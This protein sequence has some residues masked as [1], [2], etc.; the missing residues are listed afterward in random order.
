[1]GGGEE[2]VSFLFL[3]ADM[4]FSLKDKPNKLTYI[5][6]TRTENRLALDLGYFPCSLVVV[7]VQSRN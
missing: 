2:A 7:I 6:S 3:F 4:A 5:H 1:M